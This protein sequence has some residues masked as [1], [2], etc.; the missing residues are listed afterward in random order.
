MRSVNETH[1]FVYSV[2]PNGDLEHVVI[3]GTQLDW[4][5]ADLNNLSR[6]FAYRKRQQTGYSY[7]VGQERKH[8]HTTWQRSEDSFI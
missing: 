2:N 1:E 6:D 8:N 5:D 3:N 7:K 4:N